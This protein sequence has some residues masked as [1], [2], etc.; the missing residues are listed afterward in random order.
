MRGV[1][2]METVAMEMKHRGIYLAR[3]LS[4]KVVTFKAG[5]I[6]LSPKFVKSYDDSVKLWVDILQSFTKAVELVKADPICYIQCAKLSGLNFVRPTNAF[7][8]TFVLPS[9]KSMPSK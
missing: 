8:G 5:E 3:Q 1:G 7:S 4:F 6:A 2:G 9:R